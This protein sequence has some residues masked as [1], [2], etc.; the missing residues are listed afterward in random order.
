MNNMSSQR[1]WAQWIAVAGLLLV[2]AAT[3]L[4]LLKVSPGIYRWVYASGAL[5]AIAGRACAK[6]PSADLRV[7]RLCRLELWAA[8]MFGAG[9]AFM[10]IYP[11]QTDW[12]AF[13]LA[14]GAVEVYASLMLP[15]ALRQAAS[16][17][18]KS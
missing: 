9:A 3:A 5:L 12:M 10:F 1:P 13:T 18:K 11:W 6:S 14:G 17:G 2:F 8:I 7:R 15:R 16:K 4:P